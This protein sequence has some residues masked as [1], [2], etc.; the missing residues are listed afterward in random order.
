M[1]KSEFLEK[2]SEIRLGNLTRN[3]ESGNETHRSLRYGPY[4]M[5][6]ILL[7]IF[8]L[9]MVY[10]LPVNPIKPTLQVSH[11]W[12]STL[13]LQSH[14]PVTGSHLE[15]LPSLPARLQL[16]GSQPVRERPKKLSLHLSHF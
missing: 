7:P 9:E 1:Q 5:A 14:L 2:V 16:Q 10:T 8:F 15:I 11:R 3:N 12:P 6:K 4:H 13:T